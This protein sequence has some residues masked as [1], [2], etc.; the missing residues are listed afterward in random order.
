M[1]SICLPALCGFFEA[2]YPVDFARNHGPPGPTALGLREGMTKRPAQQRLSRADKSEAI[3][4]ALFGAAA[5]VVGQDGY[6][7]ASI[8]K[9]TNAAKVGQ[10]TFYNYFESRQDLFDQLLPALGDRLLDFIRARVANIE[11]D[12]QREEAGFRAFFAFLQETPEFY[13]ILNEAEI[14]APTAYHDHIRNMV[15]G[16]ARAL[17]RSRKNGAISGYDQT[18][19]EKIAL[20]L[21]SARNYLALRY[22][23]ENGQVRPLP[24][25]VVAS[26]MKF[27]AGGLGVDRE[28]VP[29]SVPQEAALKSEAQLNHAVEGLSENQVSLRVPI[30]QAAIEAGQPLPPM[31]ALKVL[32]LT[33]ALLN[34]N[35]GTAASPIDLSISQGHPVGADDLA[36]TAERETLDSATQLV[37]LQIRDGS[38]TGRLI[39]QI[40]AKFPSFNKEGENR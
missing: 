11:N 15:G 9:I 18:E 37:T 19:Y 38:S 29:P 24:E 27:V 6:A 28:M 26:Y 39:S 3:R 40:Q 5:K 31:I 4:N 35:A 2:G 10:G 30:G 34:R 23:Y 33:N 12:L 8:T 21:V 1:S 32:E 13:R 16:Y 17:E 14:F 25:H 22:S 7:D 20:I 36:V